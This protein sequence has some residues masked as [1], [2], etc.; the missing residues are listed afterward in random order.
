MTSLE[1]RVCRAQFLWSLDHRPHGQLVTSSMAT[2]KR[3]SMSSLEEITPLTVRGPA[4]PSALLGKDV[5]V[6]DALL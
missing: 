2:Q 4:C 1:R 5:A 3:F 6:E